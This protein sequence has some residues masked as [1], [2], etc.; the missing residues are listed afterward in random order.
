MRL[1]VRASCVD[2]MACFVA[3]AVAVCGVHTRTHARTR[4]RSGRHFR[5]DRDK[6]WSEVT[7][8]VLD[9]ESMIGGNLFPS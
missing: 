4:A 8:T 9:D 3:R 1:C 5:A 2:R 7:K 6:V